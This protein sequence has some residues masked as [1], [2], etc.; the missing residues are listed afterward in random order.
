[1]GYTRF[2]HGQTGSNGQFLA[3]GKVVFN[4][5]EKFE[6]QNM[7]MDINIATGHILDQEIFR[8]KTGCCKSSEG[9]T[10]DKI[11]NESEAKSDPKNHLLV[12]R[13]YSHWPYRFLQ[14]GFS[15]NIATGLVGLPV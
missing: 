11:E 13:K 14:R 2:N 10:Y 1:M 9:I 4:H 8:E 15:G 6:N 3:G 5:D 7:S 12:T